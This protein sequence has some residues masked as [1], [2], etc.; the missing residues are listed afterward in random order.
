M[1][2]TPTL[3]VSVHPLSAYYPARAWPCLLASRQDESVAATAFSEPRG[4][5]EARCGRCLAGSVTNAVGNTL[6][7]AYFCGNGLQRSAPRI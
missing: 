7:S 2:I 3:E 4:D 1:H 6:I 5:L